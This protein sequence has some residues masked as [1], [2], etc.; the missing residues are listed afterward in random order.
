M[1][2]K[3]AFA[4]Q[5]HG[6]DR[7]GLPVPCI[8]LEATTVARSGDRKPA[9]GVAAPQKHGISRQNFIDP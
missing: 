6:D 5:W 2:L 1:A 7:D 8:Q 4:K 9:V 3:I